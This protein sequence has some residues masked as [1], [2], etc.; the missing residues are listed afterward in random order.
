MEFCVAKPKQRLTAQ[1]KAAKKRRHQEYM[2]IFVHGRQRRVKRPPTIDGV[3]VEE[4]IHNNADALWY[5]QNEIWDQIELEKN[6]SDS[7]GELA[8]AGDRGGREGRNF[9]RKGR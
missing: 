7:G 4:F 2:T 8:A 6:M 1:Q 5:H 9:K 3:S